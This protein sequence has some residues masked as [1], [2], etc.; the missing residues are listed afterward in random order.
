MGEAPAANGGE[1]GILVKA[2]LLDTNQWIF[3]LKGKSPVLAKKLD[4]IDPAEVRLCS[5]VKEELYYGA[6]RHANR[7]ARIGLLH[8]IFSRHASA[9][10]DDAAAEQAGRLRGEL[11]GKG[12]PIGPHDL[13]IAAIALVRD[14]TLVTS[15]AREFQRIPGLHLEDWTR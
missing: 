14:W 2:F 7:E 9:D 1:T 10:F 12:E 5:V 3:L 15:K 11:D 8:E 4:G 6:Y 13:Q